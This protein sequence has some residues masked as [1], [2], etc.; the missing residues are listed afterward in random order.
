VSF[1]TASKA[2]LALDDLDL[3][4]ALEETVGLALER[5]LEVVR[6][7]VGLE[8]RGV[9]VAVVVLCLVDVLWRWKG[10]KVHFEDGDF[11]VLL[12]VEDLVAECAGLVGLD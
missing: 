4:R 9:F 5:S 12:V 6:V 10:G 1:S 11:L 3:G 8:G 7:A 2:R